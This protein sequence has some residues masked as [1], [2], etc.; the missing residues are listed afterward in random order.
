MPETDP[1]GPECYNAWSVVNL[2]FHHL[3]D[4]G[5][6]PTLGAG[7]DP[8]A[9]AAELLRALGIVPSAEGDKRAADERQQQLAR[10]RAAVF[11][12]G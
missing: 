5:F 1:P 3:A 10:L 4:Q 12:D 6:H 9:P 7:S 8:G 2:V 11:G